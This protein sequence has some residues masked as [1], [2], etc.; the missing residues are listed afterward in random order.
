MLHSEEPRRRKD[1][2]DCA[3]RAQQGKHPASSEPV[4]ICARSSFTARFCVMRPVTENTRI[5]SIRPVSTPAEVQAE[6]PASDNATKT[7]F[8]ARREIQDVLYGRNDRLLVIVGP[9]SIHDPKAA[10]EYAT[11]LKTLRAQLDKHL[12]IVMRVYF[13]KPRTTVGWK[14]LINDPDLND[15]YDINKGLRVGR[16]QIGRAHI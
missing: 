4:R 16:E 8:D 11:R 1:A 6:L 13:E 9:C 7:T 15:S 10:L 14:G 3:R 12:L 5:N 2:G